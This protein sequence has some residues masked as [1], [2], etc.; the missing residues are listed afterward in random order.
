M[1]KIPPGRQTTG[2]TSDSAR[3]AAHG[4]GRVTSID[5]LRGFDMVWIVGGRDLLLAILAVFLSPIPESIMYQLNHPAWVGFSAWDMIMPLFLFI[6]GTVMP[7]SFAK[8]LQQGHSKG[9][10][11]VKIV[12]RTVTLFVLGA[13]AQGNL[14]EFD[15]SRLHV[16]CNTL[17]AIACGYL[18]TA[19]LLLHLP[20]LWQ[21]LVTAALLLSYWGLLALVPV[22]EH[23]AGLL[24]PE[25]NL[26][27]YVDNLVLGRFEDG[28]TYTWILSGLGFAATVMLGALGGQLLR[29]GQAPWNKVLWLV[30]MGIGC[31]AA[32]WL[33][34]RWLPII[35]HIWSSSMV[36]WAGGWSFLLLAAFYA[37]IDVIG[38]RRWALP[39]VVVG[40]NAI[41]V[42]M[43]TR[44]IDFRHVSDPLVAGLARHLGRW[45]DPVLTAAPLAVIWLILY[46]MYRHRTFV[47]V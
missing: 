11:Y 3:D 30:L 41:A 46:Y 44:V 36:L 23:S 8:R 14:L 39:L 32:G 20:V 17:Q 12:G 28:T 26:A 31:L 1:Q 13:V 10:L 34:S 27:L 35:K 19:I 5:A 16:Y 37:V 42:Y 9:R 6:V 43:A 4:I 38:L 18:V 15:L 22:P 7:F 24:Q 2:V 47:R 45:E 21:I 25:L 40:S 29:S 33:W